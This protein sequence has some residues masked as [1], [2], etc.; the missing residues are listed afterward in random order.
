MAE[1]YRVDQ[2]AALF[3]G[4]SRVPAT[5]VGRGAGD[6]GELDAHAHRETLEQQNDDRLSELEARVS[7]LND[8]T[9]GIRQ[10]AKDSLSLLDNLGAHFDKAGSLM[11]TTAVHL[12]KMTGVKGGKSSLL[13][14]SFVALFLLIYFL[15]SLGGSSSGSGGGGGGAAA[16]ASGLR[17]ALGQ[18]SSG[19]G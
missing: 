16:D 19:K 2:R 18:N 1:R 7:Q 5:A 3:G 17:G 15:R 14:G 9:R 6:R 8:V 13:V 4:R 10:E 11:R 12:E